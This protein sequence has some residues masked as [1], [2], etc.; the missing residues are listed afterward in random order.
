MRDIVKLGLQLIANVLIFPLLL[1]YW[2][3][4]AVIGRDRALLS[5]SELLSLLPGLSGQYLRRAYLGWTLDYCHPSV[6]I[7]FGTTFSKCNARIEANVYIGSRCNIGMARIGRDVLIASG[8]YITSGARMHGISDPET[9]IREQ[10]GTFEPV[11]IGAGCWIGTCAVI[12]A[13]IGRDSVVGAG[14]VVTKPLAEKVIAGGV[15]ARLIRE[16]FPTSPEVDYAHTECS[17]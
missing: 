16:R 7:G 11:S 13:D 15:P 6:S 12:M 9:P 17:R 4:A 10:E 1:I 5:G 2:M 3:Q 8:V 14:A